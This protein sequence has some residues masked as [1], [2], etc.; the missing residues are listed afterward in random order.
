[1]ILIGNDMDTWQQPAAAGRSRGKAAR[2]LKR[3]P[4]PRKQGWSASPGY[5]AAVSQCPLFRHTAGSLWAVMEAA[6]LEDIRFC[7]TDDIHAARR[8][9][10]ND[11]GDIPPV[12]RSSRRHQALSRHL[13]VFR[14]RRRNSVGP[15]DGEPLDL[16]PPFAVNYCRR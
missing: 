5:L 14:E 13:A 10:K 2:S 15:V 1:M 11:G 12:G 3:L 8:S 16:S 6:G 7:P 4:R 9:R